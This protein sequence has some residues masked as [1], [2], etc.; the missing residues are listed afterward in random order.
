MI[1]IIKRSIFLIFCYFLSIFSGFGQISIPVVDKM[2]DMPA[3][4]K[5]LNWKQKAVEFDKVVYDFTLTGNY[6][7]FIWLD[8][9]HHNLPQ[10]T[11]G[12][13]TVIGDIRQ[14][15]GKNS[16]YHEAL[17]SLGSILGAGL[18]GIDKTNQNGFNFVK[19]AQNYFNSDNSW[20]IVMNNTNPKVAL[21]GGGY[22]RDWWYDIFPNVLFY[23]VSNI[24]PN[25]EHAREIQHSIAEKFYKAD[26]VLN[27]N[28]D[29]S[30]FDYAKMK[31][32]RAIFRISKMLLQVM[33]MFC[34][35][36]IMNL[37]ILVTWLA[38]NQL[39]VHSCNKK[40]ADFMKY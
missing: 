30:Y 8:D 21:L 12:I 19:M 24:F 34:S 18:V 7:P 27:G 36:P 38:P 9:S 10:Q 20:N 11:F 15:P 6:L 31:G 3:P 29:Y 35:A 1:T 13:Y 32:M 37:K 4:Y 5:M 28:Y 2:P 17:C 39:Y 40:K 14:G 22:G 16:E 33:P 26:S 23:G 25:V